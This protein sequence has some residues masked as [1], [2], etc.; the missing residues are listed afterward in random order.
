MRLP[1]TK[2]AEAAEMVA[3]DAARSSEI[4][5][6]QWPAVHAVAGE[7]RHHFELNGINQLIMDAVRGP[8]P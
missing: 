4:V 5:R 1:W 7:A 2:R 8:K 3:R 6:Q